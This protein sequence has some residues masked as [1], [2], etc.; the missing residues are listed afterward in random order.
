M[1]VYENIVEVVDCK[2]K[3]CDVLRL[4]GEAT[5]CRVFAVMLNPYCCLKR[6]SMNSSLETMPQRVLLYG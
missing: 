1:N 2:A 3:Y 6:F 4:A 5:V